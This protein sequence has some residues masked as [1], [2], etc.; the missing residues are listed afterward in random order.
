MP[1][2]DLHLFSPSVHS[3]QSPKPSMNA[4]D[5]EFNARQSINSVAHAT[6]EIAVLNE[7]ANEIQVTE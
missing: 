5:G 7:R 6:A 2:F 4:L 1:T 3:A